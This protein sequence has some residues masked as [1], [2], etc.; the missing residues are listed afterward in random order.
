MIAGLID[1]KNVKKTLWIKDARKN[2][3][4]MI[5]KFLEKEEHV[6]RLEN[7]FQCAK[8]HMD[9]TNFTIIKIDLYFLILIILNGLLYDTTTTNCIK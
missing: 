4:V 8:K 6:K 3:H 7:V 9:L 2:H 5:K 1:T